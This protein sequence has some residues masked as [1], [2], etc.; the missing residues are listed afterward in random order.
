MQP[1]AAQV[2][3]NDQSAAVRLMHDRLRQVIGYKRLPLACKRAGNQDGS[4][5]LVAAKLI[6]TRPQ[7]A[8]LLGSV[9]AQMRVEENVDV[10]VQVPGR[11]RAWCFQVFKPQIAGRHGGLRAVSRSKIREHGRCCARRPVVDRGRR[12]RR[13]GAIIRRGHICPLLSSLFECFVYAAH[14]FLSRVG[15]AL[16]WRK[17]PSNS[18]MLF[19]TDC[20]LASRSPEERPSEAV[21]AISSRLNSRA[22]SS[23]RR[24]GMGRR[25]STYALIM[26]CSHSRF[27][28][29][30]MPRE[31]RCTVSMA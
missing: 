12:F 10:R 1:R 20:V 29:R 7:G 19:S 3:V 14:D 27:T 18:S 2:G 5:R 15:T 8:E 13:R 25:L 16:M 9:R 31:Y 17:R 26:E 21:G 22:T 11:G 30:G 28:T 6:Q 4:K 24:A 23:T